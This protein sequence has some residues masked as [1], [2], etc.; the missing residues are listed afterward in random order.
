MPTSPPAA[1]SAHLIVAILPVRADSHR[2][3]L[4]LWCDAPGGPRR[5]NKSVA[6]PVDTTRL[7]DFINAVMKAA[8]NG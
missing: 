7:S 1:K 6:V 8:G 2:I 3:E 4:S 5:Q